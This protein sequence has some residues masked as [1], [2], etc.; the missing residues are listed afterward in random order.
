MQLEWSFKSMQIYIRTCI[1]SVCLP[2]S[3]TYNLVSLGAQLQISLTTTIVTP[4]FKLSL[5]RPIAYMYICNMHIF[6]WFES[7][8]YKFLHLHAISLCH[9]ANRLLYIHEFNKTKSEL[10][11]EIF[12]NLIVK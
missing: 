12:I 1:L 10:K 6:C 11:P 2:T 9:I 7:L 4:D 8:V 3:S 5:R